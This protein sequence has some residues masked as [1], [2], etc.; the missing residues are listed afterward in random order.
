MTIDIHRWPQA[1]RDLRKSRG[2]ADGDSLSLRLAYR[3]PYDFSSLLQF[4]R[5]R[6][7]PEIEFVDDK[8]YSRVIT[9][10]GESPDMTH[11]WLRVS[12]WPNDES[13]LKLELQNVGPRSLADTTTRVR[14]MF[15]LD[16]DPISVAAAFASDAVLRKLLARRPGL[17]IPSGWDGFEIAV[18][19][20]LGQQ[21]SVSAASALAG[22][23]ARQYGV[24]LPQTYANGL[25]RL[26]PTAQ[27]LADLDPG[28]VGTVRSRAETLK[29]MAQSLLAGHI[30][31]NP[32]RTLEQFVAQWTAIP[33]IGPWTAHYIALRALSHPDAFPAQ[34]LV[35]Q[36]ALGRDGQRLSAKELMSMAE[37][38]R[39]WRAYAVMHI[40]RDRAAAK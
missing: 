12:A 24:K 16:V 21:V 26:F 28:S 15:D 23:L 30:D 38:W 10:T 33:G 19:A 25:C 1:P 40:W 4:L 36:R 35:L 8:S 17:R 18:R 11:G 37:A 29:R 5:Q 3:P 31:F 9:V 34:D 2:A 32:G 14:R 22:K 7:L 27:V 13:A 6:A 20:I 39:P